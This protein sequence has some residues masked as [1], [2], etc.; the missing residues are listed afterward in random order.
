MPR[1]ETYERYRI[2]IHNPSDRT[3]NTLTVGLAFPGGIE[4]QTLGGHQPIDA[5]S[6][7]RIARF[8]KP[9][10][11][12]PSNATFLTNAVRIRQLPPDKVITASFLIDRSPEEAPLPGYWETEGLEEYN[13]SKRSVMVSGEYR[14][15]FKGSVYTEKREFTYVNASY[16]QSRRR[17]D[18]CIG[19]Q[20]REICPS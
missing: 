18:I 13:F 19:D 6:Y 11:N 12:R 7:S 10:S 5:S 16:R 1:N 3:L 9:Q 8:A 14:W 2:F 20:R 15:D 17:F 4:A